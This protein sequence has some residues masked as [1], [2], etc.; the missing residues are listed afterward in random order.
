MQLFSL[1][2]LGALASPTEN[3]IK[4]L[5]S[6]EQIFE[7]GQDLKIHYNFFFLFYGIHVCKSY[8]TDLVPNIIYRYFG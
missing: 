2:G 5:W 4:S 7:Y 1:D 3:K 6:F 8:I